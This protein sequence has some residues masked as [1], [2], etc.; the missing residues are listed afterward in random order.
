MPAAALASLKEKVDSIESGYEFLLAYA[1]QGLATDE[2]SAHSE[3]LRAY[4]RRMDDAITGLE[5]VLR[6]VIDAAGQGA[7][8]SD[9]L[10]LL[11]RD[12]AAARAAIKVVESR[13]GIS[14]QLVTT[15]TA[16]STSRPC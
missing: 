9:F 6:S 13:P 5:P 14:S 12:A 8:F 15:S 2:G 1:A 11:S 3:Q 4:L 16:R 10:G 7:H